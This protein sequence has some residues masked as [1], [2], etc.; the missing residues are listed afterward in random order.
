MIITLFPIRG[1]LNHQPETIGP[2]NMMALP[3]SNMEVSQP[4]GGDG[5][6]HETAWDVAMVSLGLEMARL[7]R[8]GPWNLGMTFL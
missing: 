6:A 5:F 7:D 2:L 4:F 3:P 1:W 8:F